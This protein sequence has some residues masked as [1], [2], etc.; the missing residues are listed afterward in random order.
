M[1]GVYTITNKLDG[2]QYVGSAINFNKRWRVHKSH[3]RLNKHSNKHMQRV[4]N[5]YG[6]VFIYSKLEECDNTIL[7]NREQAWLD[8]L[9]SVINGYNICKIAGKTLGFKN[10]N[11]NKIRMSVSHSKPKS[12]AWLSSR[13]N[14]ICT[15]ETRNKISAS[16]KL[17]RIE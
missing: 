4:Y 12:K 7:I 13:K 8:G 11:A 3:F 16:N 2:R 10:S 1:G 9:Q 5:K 6:D 14:Y 17:H 15:E